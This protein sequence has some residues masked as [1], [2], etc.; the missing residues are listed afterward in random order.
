MS[1]IYRMAYAIQSSRK[2]RQSRV[3]GLHHALTSDGSTPL[4]QS[5]NTRQRSIWPPLIQSVLAQ[6]FGGV[7]GV[8]YT[9]GQECNSGRCQPTHP[10]DQT[11]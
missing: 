10:S 11:H 1:G 7:G 9:P 2:R 6:F 4:I 5:V 3:K 8:G